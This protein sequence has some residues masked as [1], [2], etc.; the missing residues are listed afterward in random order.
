MSY[1][2]VAEDMI[3]KAKAHYPICPEV[4]QNST[5]KPVDCEEALRN[6]PGKSGVYTIWPRNRMTEDRSL[7]VYC[8]MD[9]DGGGWTV[10]HNF[11]LFQHD[12]VY[13]LDLSVNYVMRKS[14]K[15]FCF[16]DYRT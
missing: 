14:Y 4:I 10:R 3:A 2:D 1:L 16:A 13:R 11:S 6:G 8:D 12:N 15:T 7:E 5:S 9:T